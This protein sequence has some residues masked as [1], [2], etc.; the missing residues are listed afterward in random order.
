M[1]GYI[2]Q[3]YK[4]DICKYP[5]TLDP[6]FP[7]HT[8]GTGPKLGHRLDPLRKEVTAFSFFVHTTFF[9]ETKA[10]QGPLVVA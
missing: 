6:I 9:E 10:V 1:F 3:L 4:G 8:N 7:R 5:E 2:L